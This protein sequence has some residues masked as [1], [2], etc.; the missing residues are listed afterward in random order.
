MLHLDQSTFIVS[1]FVFIILAINKFKFIETIDKVAILFTLINSE[2][3]C[4][5]YLK[6]ILLNL[7]VIIIY[8]CIIIILNF[9]Y[10]LD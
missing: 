3:C 7:W 8:L 10:K 5:Y 2:G 1:N 4:C 6:I 9:N